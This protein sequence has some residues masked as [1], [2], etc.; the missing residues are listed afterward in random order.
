[1]A[2]GQYFSSLVDLSK[3]FLHCKLHSPIHTHTLTAHLSR[4]SITG[5]TVLFSLSHTFT[6]R[7]MHQRQCGPGKLGIKPPSCL[8][9]GYKCP[10]VWWIALSSHNKRNPG[11]NFNWGLFSWSLHVLRWYAFLL[12][13]YSTFLPLSQKLACLVNW[14]F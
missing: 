8:Y 7:W 11:L 13:R 4:Y 1:M 6:H 5:H 2:N 10:M 12:T 9:P 3:C 14:C